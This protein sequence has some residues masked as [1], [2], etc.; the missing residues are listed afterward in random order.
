MR[1]VIDAHVHLVQEIAG[2]GADGALR[3]IGGGRARYDDGKIITLLPPQF[4][5]YQ[6]TPEDVLKEMDANGIEKAVCLQGNYIGYQNLYTYEA[7]QKYPDRFLASVSYD[8][9][10]RNRDEIVKHFFEDLKI[11]VVKWEVSTGSGLMANHHTLPLDGEIMKPE[12]EYADE[13][14]LVFVIDIGKLGSESSQIPAL[15]RMILEHPTMH[16]IVCH[17]LAPRQDQR[18]E[19]KEGLR[20]LNLPNVWFDLASLAHNVRPDEPPYPVTRSFVRDAIDILGADRLIFGTDL[21][22]NLVRDTYQAL[23]NIYEEAPEFTEDEKQL[24][25]HDNAVA[26][27]FS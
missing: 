8:P 9:F 19:M 24:I 15:R 22:S 13:H 27:Y 20:A 6:A 7:S 21:P 16:V 10:S 18:E 17:L 23:I 5:E 3:P 4:G 11:P 12:F 2:T 25:L 1:K 26:A 14:G